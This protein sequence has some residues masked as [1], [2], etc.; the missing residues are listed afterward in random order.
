MM[1][2]DKY[3]RILVLNYSINSIIIGEFKTRYGEYPKFT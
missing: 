3:L 2:L 1:E